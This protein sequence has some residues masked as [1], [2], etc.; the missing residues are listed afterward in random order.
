MARAPLSLPFKAIVCT[1]LLLITVLFSLMMHAIG[2]VTKPDTW[3]N[4]GMLKWVWPANCNESLAHVGLHP[5]AAV[6]GED[7]FT[8]HM[9]LMTMAFVLLGP[10]GSLWYF[11]LEDMIGLSHGIVK[12]T[13]AAIQLGA[14][15]CSVLG[16][17]Q[18]YFS[19]GSGC[20]FSSHYE[21]LHSFIG[22]VLLAGWWLQTPFALLLF[23]N[24]TLL[25]PGSAARK[26]FHQLH[27]H[28]GKGMVLLGLFVVILGIMAFEVK[29]PQWLEDNAWLPEPLRSDIWLSF[30]RS[31]TVAFVL[32]LC[33]AVLFVWA[34][35]ATPAATPAEPTTMPP[36]LESGAPR[37]E[38]NGSDRA[39]MSGVVVP[40]ISERM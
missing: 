38:S 39:H 37:S 26:T 7:Y 9:F 4:A 36:L 28:L 16:F 40:E 12:W 5:A 2:L 21:S 8:L 27:V 10:V 1:A 31:G 6:K 35:A 14:L 18:I 17:V 19:N 25:K 3:P 32:C 24:E 22:I 34:P 20:S 33:L 23:S 11:V 30:A 15:L 13:H 29:R